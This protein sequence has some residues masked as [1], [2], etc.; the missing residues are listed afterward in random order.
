M[1]EKRFPSE[2][3]ALVAFGGNLP[4]LAGSTQVTLLSALRDIV[5]SPQI[6]VIAVSRLWQS[7]AWPAGSGPDYTNGAFAAKTSLGAEETLAFLHGIEAARGRV[8]DG[9]RWGARGIDLDLI[10]WGNRVLPDVASHD[11]WRGLPPE[12][13]ARQAP[14]R[15]ILPHPRMQDRGFVLAPLA[16]IAPG[17]VHPR[18]GQSVAQMLAALPAAALDSMK[19]LTA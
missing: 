6:R 2:T 10:A 9:R 17:W 13:Q 11:A 8:R 18:L 4:S 15:L 14:D 3:L 5:N 1:P 7:P 19:P 16:E 12:D